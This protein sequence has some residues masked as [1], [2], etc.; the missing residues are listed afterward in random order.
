MNSEQT[1]RVLLDRLNWP[2]RLARWQV[3]C[4][5]AKL[6]ESS[7]R[8]IA[9]RVYL[10]WLKSRKFEMEIASA[11]AI[12]LCTETNSLP[13]ANKVKRSIRK[14]S[15]LAELMFQ[16]VYRRTLGGWLSAHSGEA[17]ASFESEDYFE[18]HK[19]QVIP[20]ILDTTFARL[21]RRWGF[22]FLQQWAYEW[23]RL[24][25][26][27]DSPYSSFPYHF[28]NASISRSGVSGSFSLA[29]CNVYRSAFLRTLSF[30]VDQWGMPH[31]LAA[32]TACQ[33]L[34][35]NRGLQ[36][37]QP[38]R[39]PNWLGDVPEKCCKPDALLEPLV[40]QIIKPNIGAKGMRPVSLHIPISNAVAE[41]GELSV[42]GFFVTNNYES[43]PDIEEMQRRT[44][45]WDLPDLISFEGPLSRQDVDKFR[46]EGSN[47]S[48]V[49][50]CLSVWPRY[51][52]FWQSEYFSIGIAV[53][54]PYHFPSES[55]IEFKRG[56][57]M[58]SSD[59]RPVGSW[60]LWN[61]NWSSLHP[62]EGHTRC[63]GVAEMSL[64]SLNA[65]PIGH[66]MNL[67]WNV[68]LKLW[69]RPTEYGELAMTKRS[70]FFVE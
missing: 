28:I 11:L 37:L 30:A 32:M 4:E 69:Q 5:F 55:V 15:I 59:R 42:E 23:R 60:R 64:D 48:A 66:G 63:G 34:P 39:R 50:V 70:A 36:S 13:P 54:A 10:D 61:D 43:P 47:G 67:A 45:V 21:Q 7:Q 41:F 57:L 38:K 18:K 12:L 24:M 16:R 46:I 1:M 58:L 14:P 56:E 22:P 8:E 27:T 6:F 49:P 33:C 44:M 20:L 26:A 31:D 53:P 65:S 3:A 9:T 52:G 51:S 29:Q 2:L 40:R 68:Q 17:P 19:G 25:D 62:S 35:L